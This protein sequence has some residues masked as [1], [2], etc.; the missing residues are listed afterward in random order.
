MRRAPFIKNAKTL[1]LS[2]IYEVFQIKTNPKPLFR[3]HKLQHFPI[4]TNISECIFVKNPKESE[5]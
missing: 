2:K 1:S 5:K 3:H 4:E